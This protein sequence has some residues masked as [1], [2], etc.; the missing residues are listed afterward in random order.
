LFFLSALAPLRETALTDFA[1]GSILVA[2]RVIAHAKAQRRKDAKKT[3]TR[4][5]RPLTP[6]RETV[7]TGIAGESILVAK[8][9][10]ARAR[11]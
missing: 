4:L 2:K 5:P 1:G 9:L 6:L 7:L 3:E 10:I 11:E 8:R